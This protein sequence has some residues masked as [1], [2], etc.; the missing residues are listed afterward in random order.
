[1]VG[2]SCTGKT[3]TLYEAVQE[4]LPSW[5]I[6][7]PL[8]DT[9]LARTLL[10]GVP[11]HTIVWLD[12][13]QDLLTETPDGII[14][15]KVM[16]E[17]LKTN[18]RGPVLFAATVWPDNHIALL[19]RPTPERAIVG[20]GVISD[21]IAAATIVHV[22]DVFSDTDLAA[23]GEIR[24]ARIQLAIDTAS[25]A[26]FQGDGRK[27]VQVLAGGTQLVRRLYPAGKLQ[28]SDAFSPAAKRSRG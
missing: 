20:A 7:A 23:S 17:L 25:R 5:P 9:D 26:A 12:E 1:M 4:V 10:G 18:E 6:F 15:A 14:A 13:V 21:V 27:V 16:K 24:D 11:D 3:R 22:P 19:T 8:S 2:A 28:R